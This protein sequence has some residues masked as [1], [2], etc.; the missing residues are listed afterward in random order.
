[1]GDGSVRAISSSII[2]NTFNIALVPNDGL[3]LPS[4]W[5]CP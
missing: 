4:D 3:P 2:Q 5:Y 1:M